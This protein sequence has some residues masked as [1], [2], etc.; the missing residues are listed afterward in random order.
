MNTLIITTD[1]GRLKAFRVVHAPDEPS[2]TID[3]IREDDFAN[4]H[5][6]FANR[7]TDQ[8]GQFPSGGS[9][10]AAG[11][12]HGEETEARRVQLEQLAAAVDQQAQSEPDAAIFLAAP[13]PV[14]QQLLGLLTPDVRGRIAKNLALD[15]TKEPKLELL[16]RFE[17]A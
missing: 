17:S 5:S 16:R 11:E 13:K 12:R 14:N 9:G 15:L 10:M 8:A 4:D 7:D 1:L 3:L 2:P 6:R